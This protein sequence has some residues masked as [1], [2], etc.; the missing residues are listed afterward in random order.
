MACRG[1][2][3]RA[4]A[5]GQDSSLLVDLYGSLSCH[6]GLSMPWRAGQIADAMQ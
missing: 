3:G 4:M 6:L 5:G 1:R 2:W